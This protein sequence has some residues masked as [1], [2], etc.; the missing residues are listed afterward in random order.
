MI[1]LPATLVGYVESDISYYQV[2]NA[3]YSFWNKQGKEEVLN[4]TVLRTVDG[5]TQIVDAVEYRAKTPLRR[6]I[7]IDEDIVRKYIANMMS[8]D[9]ST[10]SN[11]CNDLSSGQ[12]HCPTMED[13]PA[14]GYVAFNDA[15]ASAT[16]RFIRG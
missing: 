12:A 3:E 5:E 8:G 13:D 16:W 7:Q 11:P 10:C 9:C 1:T 2:Y 15:V 14:D 6:D 4:L